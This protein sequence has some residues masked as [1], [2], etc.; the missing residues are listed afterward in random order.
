MNEE[1]FRVNIP[2]SNS[3]IFTCT[4]LSI[5]KEL[6]H[7]GYSKQFYE[8]YWKRES[9]RSASLPSS[10]LTTMENFCLKWIMNRSELIVRKE[11][12]PLP[13]SMSQVGV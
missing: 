9:A 5:T 7:F 10:A 6:S 1:V 12:T 8:V 13:L 3:G 2:E 11:G 4:R